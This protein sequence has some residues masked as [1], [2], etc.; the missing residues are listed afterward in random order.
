MW[1]KNYLD[2]IIKVCLFLFLLLITMLPV[3]HKPLFENRFFTAIDSSST[4][5]IDAALVRATSAYA[6][7]RS[8]NAV[9]S[10]FEESHL[11]VQPAGRHFAGIRWGFRSDQRSGGKIFLGYAG[12]SNRTR[13]SKSAGAHR[14]M[15]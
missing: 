3:T 1:L 8:F 13:N 14:A 10:V 6:L 4:Q 12:Q 11:Q 5:Y 7:S 9:V 15:V 2:T